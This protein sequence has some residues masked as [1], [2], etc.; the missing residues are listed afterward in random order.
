MN[1]LSILLCLV[2]S[3]SAIAEE[4][5]PCD[6]IQ[7][8]I[9]DHLPE[10]GKLCQ[11]SKG[12]VYVHL[13]DKYIHMLNEFIKDEGFE[14]PPYFSGDKQHGAHI[15]VIYVRE[16]EEYHVGKIKEAGQTITFKC[17]G[18]KTAVPTRW[19]EVAE[20]YVIPIEAPSLDRLRKK[21]GLPKAEHP[22]HITLGV[23]YREKE[24]S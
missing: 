23:K 12:F 14:L 3:I 7:A 15:S 21:Y 6:K 9:L 8:Y 19:K 17:L 1:L 10:S 20:V 4:K 24:A 2:F 18:C 11:D 13:D 22:F 5:S 16:A